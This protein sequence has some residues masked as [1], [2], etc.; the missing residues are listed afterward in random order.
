MLFDDTLV[1]SP[2]IPSLSDYICP[3]HLFRDDS[4]DIPAVSTSESTFSTANP[5]ANSTVIA[6][7]RPDSP[8]PPP[9]TELEFLEG[10]RNGTQVAHDG[11]LYTYDRTL[12]SGNVYWQCRDRLK[13]N[14][15]ARITTTGREPHSQ[16]IRLNTPHKFHLQSYNEVKRSQLVHQIKNTK[17]LDSPA[18]IVG[19]ALESAPWAVKTL[20]SDEVVNLKQQIR[21]K[22]QKVRK[23]KIWQTKCGP[24][25][26]PHRAKKTLNQVVGEKP[27]A[28]PAYNRA[29]MFSFL[30]KVGV[31]C[32]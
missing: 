19:A 25:E 1:T 22:R 27:A 30:N 3:S 32:V 26:L 18:N 5:I 17:S 21:R 4:F 12:K 24:V 11:F 9:P 20:L 29:E 14:C 13:Y 10:K 31:E 6:D 28:E 7:E 23:A 8:P 16:F 2:S 15:K